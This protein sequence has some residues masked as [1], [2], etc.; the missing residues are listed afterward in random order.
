MIVGVAPKPRPAPSSTL[1]PGPK[2]WPRAGR[3]STTAMRPRPERRAAGGALQRPAGARAGE[4]YL[5]DLDRACRLGPEGRLGQV[6]ELRSHPTVD[7]VVVR[8][9]G[10]CGRTGP[11][12]AVEA[13][14]VD[15][16]RI[17]LRAPTGWSEP[18]RVAVA[19]VPSCSAPF[20][21]TS[22][23]RRPSRAASSA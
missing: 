13:V 15:A 20:P 7:A 19:A 2:A 11:G 14:D 9:H 21:A 8:Q 17:A 23:V 5:A 3:A 4:Y 6:T 12:S 22:F 18:M 10:P 16:G 1:A